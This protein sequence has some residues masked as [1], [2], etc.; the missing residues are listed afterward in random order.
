MSIPGMTTPH[1]MFKHDVLS[2]FLCT[3]KGSADGT[4]TDGSS[5]MV[6]VKLDSDGTEIFRWQVR[7]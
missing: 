4:F 1:D 6:A 5:D 2:C 7:S 3:N